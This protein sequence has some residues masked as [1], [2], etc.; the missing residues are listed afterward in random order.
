MKPVPRSVNLALAGLFKH[1]L[2]PDVTIDPQFQ[3]RLLA[4]SGFAEHF[5]FQEYSTLLS[6]VFAAEIGVCG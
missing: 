1:P 5:P 3:R 2:R 4:A 6:P